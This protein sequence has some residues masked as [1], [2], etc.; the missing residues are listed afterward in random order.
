MSSTAFFRSRWVER[1]PHVT[2]LADGG[3]PAGFRAS[4]VSAQIKQSGEPDVGWMVCD[5]G[6]CQAY[7][8]VCMEADASQ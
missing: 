8:L 2:E 1:P 6:P 4:G 7:L 3:L 5:A